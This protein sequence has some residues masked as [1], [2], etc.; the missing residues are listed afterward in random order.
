MT[1]PLLAP[2]CEPRCEV[3]VLGMLSSRIRADVSAEMTNV[4]KRRFVNQDELLV[5]HHFLL[6]VLRTLLGRS[7]FDPSSL[8]TNN[9]LSFYR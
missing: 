9:L 5:H 8:A 1:D 2:T 7:D 6:V 4:K 3:K